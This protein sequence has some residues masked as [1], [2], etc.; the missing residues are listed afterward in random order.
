VSDTAF[1]RNV[2]MYLDFVDRSLVQEPSLPKL[3]LEIEDRMLGPR[4]QGARVLD[5]ACGEGYASRHF[6]SR[7]AREVVGVDIS[8]Q[9]IDAAKR[10]TDDPRVAFLNE[11]A[12]ELR[13]LDD[14]TFDVVVSQMAMMDIPDHRA[15]FA[16][17]HRVLK[18][19]G[20]FVF[21]MLHPCF[22]TR[23]ELPNVQ[24]WITDADGTPTAVIVR[25]YATEG[26]WKSGGDGIRGRMGSHHRK[27][28]TYINDLIAAGFAID[29]LEEPTV[30]GTG[31]FERV[32]RV[33]VTAARRPE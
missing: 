6:A 13:S 30:V 7:G 31:L 10:R 23:Y 29:G 9:L 20:A 5:V 4:I 25:D 33:I 8:P 1:D 3:L 28:S 14:E 16:S 12:H 18:P 24:P 27:L 17:V 2:E 15:A 26:F 11:D 21:S 22:E 32:P 19:G